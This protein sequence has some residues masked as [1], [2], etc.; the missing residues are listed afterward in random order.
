MK[1]DR[2]ALTVLAIL[3]LS[4]ALQSYGIHRPWSGKDAGY[5]GAFY[6]ILARNYAR[7]GFLT[8]RLGPVMNTGEARPHEFIY[9]LH[10]PPLLSILIALSFK[11]FGTQEW[12][13]RLVPLCFSLFALWILYLLSKNVWGEKIAIVATAI[14]SFI[15]MSLFYGSHVEVFGPVFLSFVLLTVYAYWK[16]LRT[17]QT[18]Y[19]LLMLFAFCL[20][21]LTEWDI[22]LLA[23]LLPM[24]AHFSKRGKRPVGKILLLPCVAFL[25]FALFLSHSYLLFGSAHVREYAKAL[26]Y[27]Q[28]LE[29]VTTFSAAM[30]PEQ[31]VQLPGP[32]QRMEGYFNWVLFGYTAPGS[33]VRRPNFI[34]WNLTQ[35]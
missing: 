33:A 7:Y 3:A 4:T 5:N 14:A 13:A 27:R 8:T 20:G 23:L 10:H 21:A 6:S 32:L 9:Y 11:A 2:P 24:H 19:L 15:P 12:A 35:T 31:T 28:R 18:R 1:I 22:Y 25:C 17:N 29:T 16:W 30:T 34:D 26:T